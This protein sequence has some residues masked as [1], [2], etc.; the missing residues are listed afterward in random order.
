MFMMILRQPGEAEGEENRQQN[1][2][3][4]EKTAS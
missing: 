3:P 1:D 2:Y 4:S